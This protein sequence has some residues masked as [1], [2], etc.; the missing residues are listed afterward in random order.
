VYNL[1]HDGRA[2]EVREKITT[3]LAVNF[4]L[5]KRKFLPGD[6]VISEGGRKSSVNGERKALRKDSR[7]EEDS[8]FLGN[9]VER[10]REGD[11]ESWHAKYTRPES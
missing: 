9:R 4:S 7:G 5:G 6:A 2:Q 11:R 8:G 10:G 3:E 1:R